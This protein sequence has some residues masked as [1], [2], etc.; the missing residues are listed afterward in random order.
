MLYRT[1]SAPISVQVEVT[2]ACNQ[3]CCYCY[4][5]WRQERSVALPRVTNQETLTKI[6]SALADAEVFFC[7]ITGGE[8][9]L[10]RG[11][12]NLTLHLLKLLGGFGIPCDLN[13][14]LTHVDTPLLKE[15]KVA[16]LRSILTSLSSYDVATHER[17]VGAVG[18]YEKSLQGIL[19][20]KEV[21]FSVGV[22]MVLTSQNQDMIYQTGMLAAK[23][24][25]RSF[26]ATRMGHPDILGDFVLVLP[27]EDAIHRSLDTLVELSRNTNLRV[28]V[29]EPYPLCFIGDMSKYSSLINKRC[30]AGT[31]TCAIGADGSVRSC[32]HSSK[33]YGNILDESL[34]IIWER[35]SDLRDGSLL[36][37]ECIE[38]PSFY[39]CGGGCRV[40]SK[41]DPRARGM[42][43][44]ASG[45]HNVIGT[46]TKTLRATPPS[47]FRVVG[48]V[49]FRN[50][51]FGGIVSSSVGKVEIAFLKHGSYEMFLEIRKEASILLEDL[52][53]RFGI[54]LA[55]AAMMISVLHQ[56]KIIEVS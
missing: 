36:P 27:T 14:N 29:L 24:G 30:S 43:P 19:C 10:S 16:G 32:P 6:A 42:D 13:S 31:T 44:L 8:P 9:L 50:E 34:K 1:L 21:G 3:L 17:I 11:V 55:E 35:M 54:G 40:A 49:C 45:S 2:E 23:L 26:F 33:V 48:G 56:K 38:C 53:R 39:I 18:A 15:L 20:A 12:Q 46:P 25:A 28:G 7:T 22:S 5:F 52:P 51:N 37:Q 4:N 47:R 41:F